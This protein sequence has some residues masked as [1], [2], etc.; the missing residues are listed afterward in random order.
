MADY[1]NYDDRDRAYG[2]FGGGRGPRGGGGPGGPRKQK[3]LPTEP[4]YTAYVGNLP[5]NTVQGDIDAIFKDLS[6]RSIRLV[7]D[8][9]TDKFKGFCYVEFDD[10]ESLKEAL[11][12]DGALLGD[13][14]LRVDIAEGRRQERGGGGFG[15]RKD[16]RGFRDD[17]FMG[18][19]S[20]GGGR[21]GD[22]RGGGGG[23]G[24][25]GGMGR[26]RDGPPRGGQTDF[27]EPSDEE[28]AQ[29]P[30]LQLKPRTV[31]GPLN[32]VANPN[33]AIFGGA[34]PREEN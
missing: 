1:D 30:R 15:F 34:K 19:R 7:R 9:E 4:P 25:G 6:I 5:F 2:S 33:S 21:P 12:Y 27:R 8:K 29:R 17:D 26:F 14:S 32:Q 28:R 18:G 16:D 3:E 11:T 13:R 22:R 31:A 24:G 10:L 23:G 20:R